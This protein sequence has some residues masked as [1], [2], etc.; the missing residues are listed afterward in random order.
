M[1]LHTLAILTLSTMASFGTS[2][3]VTNANGPALTR[4]VTNLTPAL[5]TGFGAIGIISEA[6]ITGTA[7]IDTTWS[8]LNFSQ[9]GT[10]GGA[11]STS[12]S[13]QFTFSANVDPTGGAFSGKNIYLLVGF[14]GTN[15]AT[16]NQMFVYKFDT[17]FGTADSGTPISLILGNGNIGTTLLGAENGSPETVSSGRFAAAPITSVP[18]TSTALLGAL[19]ALGLLRRR[20]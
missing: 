12:T 3:I 14:G 9:W 1:K 7:G 15:L 16:S 6:G 10:A 11:V 18:E 8:S 19:G 17:T 13:G 5:V 2:V 4:E 20:R